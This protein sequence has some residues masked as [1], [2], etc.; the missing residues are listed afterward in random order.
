MRRRRILAVGGALVGAVA[1]GVATLMYVA[2]Q[3]DPAG[4]PD[5]FLRDGRRPGTREVVVTAGASTTQGSLGADWVGMLRARLAPQG[6]E[7]VNAGVNG[8][9]SAGLRARLDEIIACAPNAVTVLIGT[10][11]IRGGT[12]TAE[13]RANLT[14]VVDR[15]TAA[16]TR[17]AVLSLPPLGEDLGSP[18]NRRVGEFNAVLRDLDGVT[19]VPLHEALVPLIPPGASGGTFGFPLA[20]RSAFEHYV[21]RRSWDTIAAGQ[22]NTVLT[23]HV[24]LSDRAGMVVTDLV[25]G[26][27]TAPDPP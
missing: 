12:S 4:T 5:D 21:L 24:H 25:A 26:W 6:H 9:T 23:D 14:A 8:D 7:V 3:R 22:G 10:N 19:Y 11:D 16:G 20:L 27:L 17:V 18:A 13:Y 15:L 1:I 2:F